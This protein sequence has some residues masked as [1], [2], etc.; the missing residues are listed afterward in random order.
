M[1]LTGCTVFDMHQTRTKT[2]VN[3]TKLEKKMHSFPIDVSLS[4]T[5]L[6]TK[7]SI[8]CVTCGTLLMYLCLVLTRKPS[9]CTFLQ[10]PSCSFPR[11]VKLLEFDC[12]SK[13]VASGLVISMGGLEDSLKKVSLGSLL[14]YLEAIK[15]KDKSETNARESSLSNNILWVLHKYKRRD[16]VI[17]PALKVLLFQLYILYQHNKHPKGCY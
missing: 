1:S 8:I 9:R 10:V 3:E 15:V 11:F 13:Y 16:R 6:H 5:P 4:P 2:D 14:D 12:Y 17:I 7:H